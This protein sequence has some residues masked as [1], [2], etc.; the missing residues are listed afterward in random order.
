MSMPNGAIREPGGTPDLFTALP[1]F[2]WRT[3]DELLK[4]NAKVGLSRKAKS[5]RE[6]SHRRRRGLL[7]SLPCDLNPFVQNETMRRHAKGFRKRS[8]KIG[9]AELQKT[10]EL[11]DAESASN[12]IAHIAA[13]CLNLPR[14]QSAF[15]TPRGSS[16]VVAIVHMR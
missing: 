8:T 2:R 7:Q 6:L 13:H 5:V 9:R 14:R 3:T 16:T 12:M 15:E 1:K 4:D 11:D 10:R